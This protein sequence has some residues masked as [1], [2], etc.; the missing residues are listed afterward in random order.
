[1]FRSRLKVLLFLGLL[2]QL[3]YVDARAQAGAQ[4]IRLVVPYAAGGPGDSC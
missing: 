4:P 3:V 2:A 1:M